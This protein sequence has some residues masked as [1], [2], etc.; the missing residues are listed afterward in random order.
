MMRRRFSP[1]INMVSSCAIASMCRFA[2][3][4]SPG[5]TVANAFWMNAVKSERRIESRTA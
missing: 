3:K 2:E 1:R 4:P 5:L